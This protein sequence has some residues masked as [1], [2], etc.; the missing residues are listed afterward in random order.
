VTY[1]EDFPDF[2][3]ADIPDVFRSA[4]WRD[5]S[6]RNDTCPSFA[7]NLPN[8]CEAHVYV[9]Y[10]DLAMRDVWTGRGGEQD[11]MPRFTMRVTNDDGE[12]TDDGLSHSSDSL[13]VILDHI[14][15]LAGETR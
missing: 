13:A 7:R 8:G 9:D 14:A 12:F 3:D 5:V 6:W 2:P 1:K 4:P 11:A 10:S 15:H